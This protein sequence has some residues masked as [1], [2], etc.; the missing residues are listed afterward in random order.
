[1]K[2]NEIFY[3]PSLEVFGDWN[4]LQKF[5]ERRGNPLF[6]IG[7]NLNLSYSNIKSL[8]ALTSVGGYLYLSGC[9]N[10]TSLGNLTSVGGNLDLKGTPIS[11][12]YSVKQIK[13]MVKVGG[14]IY[15]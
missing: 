3:I 8:G 15:L 2:N 13:Q 7:G 9:E 1:M 5:L 11:K 10:L 6:S 4:T 12:K 14:D